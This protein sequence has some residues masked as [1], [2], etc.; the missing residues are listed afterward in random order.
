MGFLDRFR[1]KSTDVVDAK[2]DQIGSG[3]DKAAD[4]AD[5]KTG[6]KHSAQIDK[7]ADS[8]KDTLDSLDGKND[9]IP[10]TPAQPPTQQTTQ[11]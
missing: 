8:A 10:D 5:D 6:G 2:G 1:K 3:I 9:D 4:V 7:G 11:P